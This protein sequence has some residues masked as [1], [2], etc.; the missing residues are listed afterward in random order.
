CLQ[1][2]KAVAAI[3]DVG[4]Y[5]DSDEN[6]CRTRTRTPSK[7]A[8]HGPALFHR[9]LPIN[10]Y[11]TTLRHMRR[12]VAD[13]SVRG[14]RNFL[15][16]GSRG[17]MIHGLADHLP[18][19][20]VMVSFAG[21]LSPNFFK[22]SDPAL[23]FDLCLCDLTPAGFE[24]LQKITDVVKPMMSPGGTIAVLEFNASLEVR[25]ED[26]GYVAARSVSLHHARSS[27][28]FHVLHF[29]ITCARAFGLGRL[30]RGGLR[31]ILQNVPSARKTGLARR[32]LELLAG[33]GRPFP[34]TSLT[35]EF[36]VE[37][38]DAIPLSMPALR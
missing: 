21:S 19:I 27:V 29:F 9:R 28:I 2:K 34:W 5:C 33:T 26:F 22:F 13:A 7:T 20:H 10:P 1:G 32:A 6:G 15:T 4:I 8:R 11:W 35:V 31:W 18:G 16:V 12:I 25:A 36:R 23:K 30:Y 37:H 17:N 14:D 3:P 24:V 38:Q